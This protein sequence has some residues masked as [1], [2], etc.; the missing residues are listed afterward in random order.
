MMEELAPLLNELP[1]GISQEILGSLMGIFRLL[2]DLDVARSEL[3][4][5]VALIEAEQIVAER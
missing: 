1:R 5:R 4:R 2:R 3:E